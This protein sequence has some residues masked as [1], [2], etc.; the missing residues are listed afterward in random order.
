MADIRPR[1]NLAVGLARTTPWGPGDIAFASAT[2]GWLAAGT[3]LWR[4]TDA[5]A[6][7]TSQITGGDPVTW[8]QAEDASS[9]WMRR[10]DRLWRTTDGGA[11]WGQLAGT[12][13]DRVRFRNAD[14]G[15]GRE[16]R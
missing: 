1:G 11:T 14:R 2:S 3:T 15:L 9:A 5:G 12:P 8:V 16:R 6:N 4:S 7:W 10:S 13:P